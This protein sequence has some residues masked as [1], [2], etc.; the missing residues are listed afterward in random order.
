TAT[1]RRRCWPST[2]STSASAPRRPWSAASCSCAASARCTASPRT[3][4]LAEIAL[5]RPL[6]PWGGG[7]GCGV[8]GFI[9]QQASHPPP[10]HAPPTP[11]RGGREKNPHHPPASFFYAAPTPP[12]GP[13]T[14]PGVPLG[15]PP[16]P[17]PPPRNREGPAM[18]R[19]LSAFLG[20][21]VCAT[22]TR[23]DNWP[24]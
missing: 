23:A 14:P 20:V 15:V 21:M 22:T 7:L 11:P 2:A 10:R 17:P 18:P 1:R 6:P 9:P 12:R 4:H 16:P 5:S 19:H 8:R 13:P 3:K 24:A